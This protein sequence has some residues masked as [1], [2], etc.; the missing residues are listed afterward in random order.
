MLSSFRLDAAGRLVLG[1]VGALRG[2]GQGGHPAWGQRALARLFPQLKGVPFG[3]AWEQ[4]YER[5]A[6]VLHAFGARI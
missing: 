1:S 4:G 6:L 5:G 3:H 2:L